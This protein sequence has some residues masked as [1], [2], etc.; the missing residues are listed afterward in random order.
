MS[1]PLEYFLFRPYSKAVKAWLNETTHLNRY[2]ND[3][4]VLV[5][6]ATPARAFS[7]FIYPIENGQLA[8]P[9]ISFFITAYPYATGENNLGFVRRYAYD[10]ATNTTRISKPPLVYKLTY[11]VVI[12]T[13]KMSDMDIIL[14]QIINA[15]NFN[16][17][18]VK[19]VDGQW[20]EVY[21]TD[22]RNETN[23]EPGD[24]QDRIIRYGLDL[25]IP[26]AYIPREYE[27][28]TSIE[29]WELAYSAIGDSTLEDYDISYGKTGDSEVD[30][31]IDC[32]LEEKN[33]PVITTSNLV[34]EKEV[35]VNLDQVKD[36][37][38]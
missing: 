26:R 12:R 36:P 21:A 13:V 29:D 23:L 28:I 7:R 2:P 6:Y 32:P 24:A 9:T 18:G 16:A 14:F 15:G 19:N 33:S 38:K 17:R 27:D 3:Q 35:E 20:M 34:E 1:Q 8:Q 25:V 31:T 5:I 11:N 37:K 22:P 30:F 10:S 4:N